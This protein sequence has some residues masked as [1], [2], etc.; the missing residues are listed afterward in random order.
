MPKLR[1]RLSTR[2]LVITALAV[3][4]AEVLIFVPSVSRFRYDWLTAKT[5]TVAVAGLASEEV[6]AGPGSVLGPN[7]ESALL[8]ALD[9]QLI[10][11]DDKDASRLLARAETVGVPDLQINL[12]DETMMAMI[13]GAFDTLI[14]GGDRLM[15]VQGAVGDGSV[16]AEVVM[17]ERPLRTAMLVY[18]R[19]V[20]LLSLSIAM[21]AALLVYT[22]ISRYLVRPILHMTHSMM[23]FGAN[24]TDTDRII[25]PS[26][27]DDEIGVAQVELAAMQRRLTETLR[28]QRHL[29]DLGLAVSKINHDLRNILASSQMISDRLATIEDP[30]VQRFAPLLLRS[31]DR[32][33]HYTQSV[34]AYG[35]A[36]ESE[37]VRREVR[38]RMLV[39][40]VYETLALD[41]RSQIRLVNAVPDDLVAMVDPDQFHRVILNL[42][43]NAV[44][45]LSSGGDDPSMVVRQIR[46]G[47][48]IA[49]AGAGG[50]GG[51]T[52][53]VEDTGPGLPEVARENLF[54]AFRGSARSGGTGLGLP[55]AAEIVEAHGGEISLADRD[56][57]GTRFEICLEGRAARRE[58][59]VARV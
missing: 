15:R 9:A 29:A 54:K 8:K 16:R 55:I 6:D 59:V 53:F 7:Q 27:R 45:A 32:A 38:L 3:M 37:P 42:C 25:A 21:F 47:A 31:L 12:S 44:E 23:R 28:E 35:R 40:D 26:D 51:L 43:R 49:S 18:S 17:S 33:L 13:L 34:L 56:Q 52:I 11:I 48:Q 39:E 58:A 41:P 24:P 10:A 20:F 14:L 19:N 50:W 2:I 46:T 1:R 22:A 36:V 57:P 4:L 30:T 5:E